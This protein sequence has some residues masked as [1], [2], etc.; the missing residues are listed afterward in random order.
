VTQ[1]NSFRN[2]LIRMQAMSSIKMAVCFCQHVETVYMLM[3]FV[4]RNSTVA[5]MHACTYVT[6]E[7]L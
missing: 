5:K 2:M 7:I 3:R 6:C 4:C 1:C